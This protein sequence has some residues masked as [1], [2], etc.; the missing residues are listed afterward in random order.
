SHNPL[1]PVSGGMQA[2]SYFQPFNNTNNA[3]APSLRDTVASETPD[4][5]SEGTY[6]YNTDKGKVD[7]VPV[8]GDDDL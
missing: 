4:D 7:E 1:T 2:P 3:D 8:E 6:V 5:A